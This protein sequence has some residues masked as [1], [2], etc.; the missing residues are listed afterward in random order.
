M[1][2]ER[3]LKWK[4]SRLES[5]INKLETQSSKL[6]RELKLKNVKCRNYT[7]LTQM[8]KNSSTTS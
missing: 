1:R 7:S 5:K 6:R 8:Q 2:D 3:F 4:I